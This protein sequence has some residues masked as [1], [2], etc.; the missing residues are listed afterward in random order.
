[1]GRKFPKGTHGDAANAVLAA[2]GT[3]SVGSSAGSPFSVPSSRPCS[4]TQERRPP[5][6]RRRLTPSDQAIV[7]RTGV[8]YYFM[9]TDLEKAHAG[10]HRSARIQPR[11]DRRTDVYELSFNGKRH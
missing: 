7:P 9:A 2:A 4:P 8:I 11:L 3:T 6:P 10:Q 5:V 1:M